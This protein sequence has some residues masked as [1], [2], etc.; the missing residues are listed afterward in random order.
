MSENFQLHSQVQGSESNNDIKEQTLDAINTSQQILSTLKESYGEKGPQYQ[1]ALLEHKELQQ[2]IQKAIK[3]E[4]TITQ[5]EL[6]NIM[7][8]FKDVTN[9]ES[10][11]DWVTRTLPSI[12]SSTNKLI[13]NENQLIHKDVDEYS[14]QDAQNGLKYLQNNKGQY[15]N[16]MTGFWYRTY[17]IS[18][19]KDIADMENF[20]IKLQKIIETGNDKAAR[21]EKKVDENVKKVREKQKSYPDNKYTQ[22]LNEEINIQERQFKETYVLY[23]EWKISIEKLELEAEDI[24][25]LNSIDN[26]VEALLEGAIYYTRALIETDIYK[27][28]EIHKK[29]NLIYLVSKAQ[30]I[31]GTDTFKVKRNEIALKIAKQEMWPSDMIFKNDVIWSG[32]LNIWKIHSYIKDR[33][34]DN[35]D[36]SEID[37]IHL[38]AFLTALWGN[39]NSEKISTDIFKQIAIVYPRSFI[40]HISK[41]FSGEMWYAFASLKQDMTYLKEF[42]SIDNVLALDTIHKLEKATKDLNETEKES[43]KDKILEGANIDFQEKLLNAKECDLNDVLKEWKWVLIEKKLDKIRPQFIEKY[44]W[45]DNSEEILQA[46]SSIIKKSI[47]SGLTGEAIIAD[48]IRKEAQQIPK[49]INNYEKYKLSKVDLKNITTSIVTIGTTISNSLNNISSETLTEQQI[50]NKEFILEEITKENNILEQRINLLDRATDKQ[51]DRAID[52]IAQWQDFDE[53]DTYL[54]S[55]NEAY[56]QLLKEQELQKQQEQSIIRLDSID[57]KSSTDTSYTLASQPV[58][59]WNT[60]SFTTDTW[61]Q[62]DNISTKEYKQL[63][64]ETTTDDY[65]IV[66]TTVGNEIAMKNLVDFKEITWELDMDFV[67]NF[68]NELIFL[69]RE[70]WDSLWID[71]NDND[72]M[73]KDELHKLFNFILTL[74][75][76][77]WSSNSISG[78]YAKIIKLNGSWI[79]GGKRD[80][81]TWYGIIGQKFMELWYIW[82]TSMNNKNMNNIRNYQTQLNIKSMT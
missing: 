28:K 42:N 51:F 14:I 81:Y 63:G 5:N 69:A 65:G 19:V 64:I 35:E 76:E 36:Y 25:L 74:I 31:T 11:T 26:A 30:D 33:N 70:M 7:G 66:T 52:M 77:E 39:I 54:S 32:F 3:S 58:T 21:I 2:S 71:N 48:I 8:E 68:K 56:E 82:E 53:V 41:T 62:I 37:T 80:T 29:M 73:G 61:I 17:T 78:T 72:L 22:W 15:N 67:W 10:Y 40:R 16:S 34:D 50:I 44:K 27:L 18:D 4:N 46:I 23:R 60:Y 24:L 79:L 49:L 45:L 47:K 59:N 20:I 38:I 13:S 12:F 9:L 43:G 55:V 6:S 75:W 1:N 57:T